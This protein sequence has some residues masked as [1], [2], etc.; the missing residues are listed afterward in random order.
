MCL[1]SNLFSL[2]PTTFLLKAWSSRILQGPNCSLQSAWIVTAGPFERHNWSQITPCLESSP[3]LSSRPLGIQSRPL[4]IYKA[5]TETAAATNLCGQKLVAEGGGRSPLPAAEADTFGRSW[6]LLGVSSPGPFR[7]VALLVSWV[8]GDCSRSCHSMGQGR[9]GGR[10][11][12]ASRMRSCSH[13]RTKLHH[14]ATP[15]CQGGWEIL[16]LAG[17]SCAQPTLLLRQ[18]KGR[19]K[20]EDG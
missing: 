15:G 2:L 6:P 1:G 4:S 20:W 16:C 10:E 14:V 17:W 11:Q 5:P 13:P 18:R 9:K 19:R 7:L 8:Q 3:P 12:A